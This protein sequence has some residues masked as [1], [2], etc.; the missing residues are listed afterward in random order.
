ML[1]LLIMHKVIFRKETTMPLI[2]GTFGPLSKEKKS[3]LI[4]RFTDIAAEVTN[5]PKEA[6]LVLIEEIG[7]DSTGSGGK[8]IEKIMEEVKK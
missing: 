6:F 1:I 7:M 3:E 8:T 2:R 4:R 5:H